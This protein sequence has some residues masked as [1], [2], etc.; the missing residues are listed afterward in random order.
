MQSNQ[1]RGNFA[2]SRP[3]RSYK[4]IWRGKY[5]ENPCSV[6]AKSVV[7]SYSIH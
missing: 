2:K 1:E 3:I 6:G 5:L 4:I 7:K